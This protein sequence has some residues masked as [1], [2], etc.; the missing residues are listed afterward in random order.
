[1][2]FIVFML[3]FTVVCGLLDARIGNGS[4]SNSGSGNHSGSGDQKGYS[5]QNGFGNHHG[6]RSGTKGVH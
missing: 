2:S 6:R 3:L 4:A 5:N 1:M